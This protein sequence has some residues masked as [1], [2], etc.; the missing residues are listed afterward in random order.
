MRER[1]FTL[2]HKLS[3]M[4]FGQDRYRRRYWV[5]PKCG[6]IFVEGLESGEPESADLH[7]PEIDRKTED[8][9]VD[10]EQCFKPVAPPNTED[11]SVAV[12]QTENR[13][14]PANANGTAEREVI[15]DLT[16][17]APD[18]SSLEPS[19]SD[20]KVDV[21]SDD[22]KTE[23]CSVIKQESETAAESNGSR[24]STLKAE[25]VSLNCLIGDDVKVNGEVSATDCKNGFVDLKN[26]IR[27]DA[28]S[29]KVE[30]LSTSLA[31]ANVSHTKPGSLLGDDSC[32][33]DVQDEVPGAADTELISVAESAT[34]DSIQF[35]VCCKPDDDQKPR[36]PC[37]DDVSLIRQQS[38]VLH[39]AMS[40]AGLSQSYSVASSSQR[41]SQVATPS[42]EVG[43]A[44][45]QLDLSTASTPVS[46]MHQTSQVSTP[47]CLSASFADDLQMSVDGELQ[48]DYLAVPQNVQPI[49]LG[50]LRTSICVF[51]CI[52]MLTR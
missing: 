52:R 5:L 8:K 1:V 10:K 27:S 49:S 39:L 4:T 33:M 18:E 51:C 11:N 16:V 12:E 50:Y 36:T 31:A 23:G 28:G 45:P 30:P 3:A 7:A 47:V 42:S 13:C 40:S 38:A 26:C 19:L 15:T 34:N 25:L 6:G 29:V 43:G 44:G 41:T 17:Q 35:S 2:A 32:S 24:Y 46:F 21:P 20:H 48:P 22:D 9:S 14:T 37:K